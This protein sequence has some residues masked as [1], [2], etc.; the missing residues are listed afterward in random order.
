MPKGHTVIINIRILKDLLAKNVVLNSRYILRKL[1]EENTKQQQIL[2]MFI[3]L[4]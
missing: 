1:I 2:K 4:R 3:N